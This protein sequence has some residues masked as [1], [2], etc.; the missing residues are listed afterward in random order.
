MSYQGT[1]LESG[2]VTFFPVSGGKHAVGMISKGGA[3]TLSTFES[4]DGAIIGKHKVIIN[5]SYETPDGKSVPD[6]VPRVPKKYTNRD[7]TPL[8]VDIVEDGSPISL[9]LE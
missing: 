8:E 9:K 6:S 3:F 2:T 1:P 7:T 4:G 5:V